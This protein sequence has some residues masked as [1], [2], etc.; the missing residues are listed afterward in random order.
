MWLFLWDSEPS[1]IFVGDTSISKVF[2]WDTQVRPSWPKPRPIITWFTYDNKSHSLYTNSSWQWTMA[3]SE[4]WTRLYTASEDS[5]N[6]WV[7]QYSLSTPR[8]VSTLSYVQK[9]SI[10]ENVC[11]SVYLK[12]W[13]SDIFVLEKWN[14]STPYKW[15]M[16]TPY[17]V[18]TATEQSNAWNLKLECWWLRFS[19]DGK[20]LFIN[21]RVDR[22]LFR[23]EL[24]T[25][26]DLAST[27]TF[28]DSL[29]LSTSRWQWIIFNPQWTQLFWI[30]R[31]DGSQNKTIWYCTLSTPR[32]LTTAGTINTFSLG[33]SWDP[34]W[35]WMSADGSKLYVS[36]YST[37]I[38]QYSTIT[39]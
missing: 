6:V 16:S 3:F 19:P 36:R 30:N 29:V 22:T 25:P 17:D 2:L 33:S 32:D 23:Y 18:T 8:D 28:K 14:Q 20:Y 9:L 15:T 21:Q 26:R 35:I 39:S 24:A 13:W 7:H 5:W 1:K 31:F 27:K 34:F 38:Y 11:N 37:G 10:N 4:D 12:E